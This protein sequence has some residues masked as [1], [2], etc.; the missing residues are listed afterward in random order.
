[1]AFPPGGKPIFLLSDA[2]IGQINN[3]SRML[4]LGLE[5]C[6]IAF[7][8]RF[9]LRQ[10]IFDNVLYIN[11]RDRFSSL[12]AMGWNYIKDIGKVDWVCVHTTMPNLPRR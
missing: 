6:V 8:T 10:A 4:T 2:I 7:K 11:Y 12:P 9:I 3:E 1:M 5:S